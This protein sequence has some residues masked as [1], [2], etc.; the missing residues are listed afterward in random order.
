MQIK[1]R[2]HLLDIW[3][4]AA[5]HSFD[6]GKLVCASRCTIAVVDKPGKPPG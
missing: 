3:R 5:R 4:A 1:P 2:Q 6:D